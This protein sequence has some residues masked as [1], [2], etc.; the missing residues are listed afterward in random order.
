MAE[1]GRL[2]PREHFT[3][4][5][6]D[7]A[8]RAVVPVKP[9]R[10]GRLGMYTCGPTVYAPQHIG[11]MRSQ[12]FADLLRRA[13]EAS[14]LEVTHVINI[15]DVGHLTSDADAGDDKIEA[16]AASSGETAAEIAARY[17]KQWQ[18][19]R[20][21][22]G[23]KD[24]EVMPKATDHIDDMIQLISAIAASG[25]TYPTDDGLYFDSRSFPGY[26]EFARLQ[27]DAQQATERIEYAHEKRNSSD[28]AL[29]KLSPRGSTRQ[30]EWDSP[31]GVGFPGWHIECSAMATRYLGDHF[32][33]HTG[34]IDHIP[35]H[36]TNEIAQSE[37]GFGVHP[38]VNHWVHHDFLQFDSDKMSKSGGTTL[39]VQDLV[40]QGFDPLAFRF[41]MLQG[42]YHAP[43][44]FSLDAMESAATALERYLRRAIDFREE[45]EAAG[46]SPDPKRCRPYRDRFW[47]A[48]ANDLNTPVALG[49]AWDVIRT[50]DLEP[51]DKYA[52]LLDFDDVLGLGVEEAERLTVPISDEVLEL[53]RQRDDARAHKD[54]AEADRLR[55]EIAAQGFDVVDTPDGTRLEPRA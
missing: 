46:A 9:I 53:A 32:D 1:S 26:G 21:R 50:D 47:E 12:I 8:A 55:D 44:A 51:A 39:L 7:T 23:C 14:G 24:P 48:I 42:H 35:V 54:W 30:Q 49:V 4:S 34:G 2:P 13:F 22:L 40:D 29:W 25:H 15:T 20:T 28:F 37:T 16:A 17:T 3:V 10:P 33:V 38:W 41:L 45:A 18:D 43:M 52:L 19:D 31:W 36:H 11:N 5:I 27:L 6:T